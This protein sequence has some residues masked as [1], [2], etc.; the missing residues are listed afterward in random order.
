MIAAAHPRAT[1]L[2]NVVINSLVL[3]DQTVAS[4]FGS[5]ESDSIN[6]QLTISM[7]NTEMDAVC[8]NLQVQN[9]ASYVCVD[10]V[11]QCL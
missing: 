1:H 4:V 6:L 5:T 7:P 2:F 9:R 3:F 11:V 8:N 10:S